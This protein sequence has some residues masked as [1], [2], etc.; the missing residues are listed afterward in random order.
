MVKKEKKDKKEKFMSFNSKDFKGFTFRSGPVKSKTTQ[1]SSFWL[2]DN[3]DVNVDEFLGLDT[4][5]KG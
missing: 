3:D 2:N 4:E 1:N 5:K